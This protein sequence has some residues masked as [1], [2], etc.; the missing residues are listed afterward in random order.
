LQ[1]QPCIPFIDEHRFAVPEST[2]LL[3]L[4]SMDDRRRTFHG[5]FV[6]L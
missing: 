5:Q 2:S 4:T 6:V 1:P 3:P